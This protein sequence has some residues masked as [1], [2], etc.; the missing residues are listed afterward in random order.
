MPARRRR[1][2]AVAASA[3]GAAALTLL[4][5]LSIMAPTRRAL[6]RNTSD[7]PDGAD[8]EPRLGVRG[9]GTLRFMGLAVYEAELAVAAGFDPARPEASAFELKLAYLRKLSG[10]AIVDRSI[11]EMRRG[12]EIAPADEARWREFMAR[13]FPDVN[14][15]DVIVGRWQPR[16]AS[17]SFAHNAGAPVELLDPVFGPRFFGIWLAPHSSQPELRE[18]LL[19]RSA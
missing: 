2:H 14:R 11:Q 6:A 13:A 12:G 9:R 8:G 19:G 16:T 4:L 18:R 17:S 10:A 5:P 15:G 7:T 3:L 1:F